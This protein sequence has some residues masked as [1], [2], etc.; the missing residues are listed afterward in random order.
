[1]ENGKGFQMKSELWYHL[2]E[3]TLRRSVESRSNYLKIAR[4]FGFITILLIYFICYK[5]F[6]LFSYPLTKFVPRTKRIYEE[7]F[8]AGFWTLCCYILV[9]DFKLIKGYS[10][11]KQFAN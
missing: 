5:V 11:L 8:E 3:N 1:M 2:G 4:T 10:Y 6:L 9:S 7:Y